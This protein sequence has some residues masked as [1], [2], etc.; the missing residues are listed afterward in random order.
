MKELEKIKT[1]DQLLRFLQSKDNFWIGFNKN[2][3]RDIVNKTI[4]IMTQVNSQMTINWMYMAF[5]FEREGTVEDLKKK[6]SEWLASKQ[7]GVGD[8]QDNQQEVK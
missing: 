3:V 1:L 8:G 6:F 5:A 4:E 2:G 7:V